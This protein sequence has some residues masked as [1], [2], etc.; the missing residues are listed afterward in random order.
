MAPKNR[1]RLNAQ[2]ILVWFLGVIVSYY[3]TQAFLPYLPPLKII[4]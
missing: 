3:V 1:G 4:S 2:S